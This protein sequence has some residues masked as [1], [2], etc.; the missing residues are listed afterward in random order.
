MGLRVEQEYSL[1]AILCAHSAYSVSAST[2]DARCTGHG[3]LLGHAVC[4][5]TCQGNRVLP[6]GL[7]SVGAL[8]SHGCAEV[9]EP[10]L[11]SGDEPGNKPPFASPQ[12]TLCFQW[13]EMK[14]KHPRVSQWT[15]MGAQ[16]AGEGDRNEIN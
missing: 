16:P 12:S 1:A 8:I 5:S 14:R 13:V 2:L 7:L 4:P 10:P 3:C 15:L 9:F 6:S 11:H